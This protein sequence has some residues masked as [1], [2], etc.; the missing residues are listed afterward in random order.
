MGKINYLVPLIPQEDNPICWI[1]CVAMVKSW[2][3]QATLS[4]ADFT[5]GA[6]PSNSCISNV[7]IAGFKRRLRDFGFVLD[8]RNMSINY[9][10]IESRLRQN[11]PFIFFVYV[12]NFPFFGPYCLNVRGGAKDSHAMIVTGMDTDKEE[13]Y[14]MNPWGT[15][16]PPVKLDDLVGLLQEFADD[17]RDPVAFLP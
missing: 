13:V 15:E 2:K 8:G 14:I 12:A 9:Q 11:G 1:A 16:V 6:D 17:G 5:G 4:I 7:D 3:E 10:Y